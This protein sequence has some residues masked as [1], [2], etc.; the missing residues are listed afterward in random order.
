M[1]TIRPNSLSDFIGQEN[2]RQILSVLITATKRRN[3][4]VL[5]HLLMSGGPGLGK[6]T[7]ARLIASE[8]GGRLVEVVASSVKTP[9]E[10]TERLLA[11]RERDVLFIDEIHAL[12]RPIEEQLYGALEDG[13]VAVSHKNYNQ[14]MRN[15][16]I[17]GNGSDGDSRTQQ[18]LP[19]FSLI[20]AT[21]L[22]GLCS[23]PLR[24]RFA[25]IIEL[26]PYDVESLRLI[27]SA[28]AKKLRFELADEIAHQIALRSRNTARIAVGNLVW[29]R[30]YV[31]A[32]GGVA[33]IEALEAAF[34]LKGIDAT[35]LTR[36]DRGYL[37][38]LA[39]NEDAVGLDTL[40]A[41]LGESAETL[42]ESVEPFLLRQGLIQR[43]ARGRLATHKGRQVL[44][45]VAV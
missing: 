3:E 22:L 23:A 28:A 29:Y 37:R 15:I 27:I 25:Q 39:E 4:P 12:G 43:T 38:C 40:A 31:M 36:A 34:H 41:T 32:D 33:T 26:E 13:I 24:S 16:G 14:L 17:R 30:D 18:R 7:L 2:A 44:A 45:E 6:T 10:M 5:P 11:L 9:T 8:M 35:G 19:Q 1:S 20:G 42:E 21:T